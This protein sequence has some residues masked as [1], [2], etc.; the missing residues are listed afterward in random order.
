MKNTLFTFL[1]FLLTLSLSAQKKYLTDSLS[2]KNLSKEIVNLF[3][4]N[5]ISL[6][7]EKLAPFWPLP[8]SELDLFEEKTIKNI[9]VIEQRYGKPVGVL[10]IK[11][12]TISNIAIRETYIIHYQISAIRLIFTYYKNN[13]GWILNAFKWDDSFENEFK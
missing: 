13:K 12:E 2:T 10:K 11:N 5:K 9:N 4:E 7:I 6:A 1:I 3:N 8:Q